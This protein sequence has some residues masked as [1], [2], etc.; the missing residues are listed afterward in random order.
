LV[1][2][3]ILS[4]FCGEP[5]LALTVALSNR[6]FLVV[7]RPEP[8]RDGI[9]F[10]EKTVRLVLIDVLPLPQG[11]GRD[12]DRTADVHGEVVKKILA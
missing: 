7:A 5:P 9:E 6:L 10:S 3:S 1:V 11:E 2:I 4:G 12:A 8:D